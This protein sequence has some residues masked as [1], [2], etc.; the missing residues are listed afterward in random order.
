MSGLN[1]GRQEQ[2]GERRACGGHACDNSWLDFGCGLAQGLG[3]LGDI[4]GDGDEMAED[5]SVARMKVAS[6]SYVSGSGG[7]GERRRT[8][9]TVKSGG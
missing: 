3:S 5:T 4:V 6:N 7:R 9:R 2:L 1:D 8:Q